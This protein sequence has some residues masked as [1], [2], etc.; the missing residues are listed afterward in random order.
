MDSN[1]QRNHTRCTRNKEE[2]NQ[3]CSLRVCARASSFCFEWCQC[4]PRYTSPFL[5]SSVFLLHYAVAAV[6]APPRSGVVGVSPQYDV[7]ASACRCQGCR[8]AL[9]STER[10]RSVSQS[11]HVHTSDH[12]GWCTTG[13]KSHQTRAEFSPTGRHSNIGVHV[14]TSTAVASGV[15]PDQGRV[16]LGPKS[17]QTGRYGNVSARV[18]TSAAVVGG[19]S[20]VKVAPGVGQIQ[21][22]RVCTVTSAF[23]YTPRRPQQV[24]R[25]RI[26]VAPNSCQ[27]QSRQIRHSN[28][29]VRV[30]TPA[31][32]AG[33]ALPD[34]GRTKLRAKFGASG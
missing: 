20:P 18:Y 5:H 7:A 10:R 15:S 30:Y 26:K 13:S 34:Q 1:S 25:S 22:R 12:R 2:G 6:G 33:G 16:V 23:A 9:V 11:V 31:R 8:Y 19:A 4:T 32:S 21:S 29:S 27:I 14:Y 17:V 28:I 3:Y 24:V